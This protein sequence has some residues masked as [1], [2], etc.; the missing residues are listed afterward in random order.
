MPSLKLPSF[1]ST[2]NTIAPQGDKAGLMYPLSRISFSCNFNYTSSRILILYGA[3]DSRV[4][5]G[6]NSIENYTYYDVEILKYL[7]EMHP[8]TIVR[9]GTLLIPPHPLLPYHFH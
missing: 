1:F 9:L 3:F 7:R 4:S 5:L 6:T 8:K 2:N